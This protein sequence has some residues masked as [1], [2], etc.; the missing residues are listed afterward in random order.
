MYQKRSAILFQVPLQCIG[1]S[2]D[3]ICNHPLICNR[4]APAVHRKLEL[5]SFSLCSALSKKTFLFKRVV[6]IES[7][8][9]RI[10]T[11]STAEIYP[12][13]CT[14]NVMTKVK[15]TDAQHFLFC[16]EMFSNAFFYRLFKTCYSLMFISLI[17]ALTLYHTTKIGLDQIERI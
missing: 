14:E 17:Q 9:A 15:I 16:P 7:F 2:K 13:N 1:A 4:R 5:L 12:Y 3:R 6:R 11:C 10:L 8:V